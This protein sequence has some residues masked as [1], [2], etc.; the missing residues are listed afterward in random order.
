MHPVVAI[1]AHAVVCLRARICVGMRMR[2]N[3]SC[4]C[5][6]TT[7]VVPA[8]DF[9]LRT[10]LMFGRHGTCV[11]REARVLPGQHDIHSTMLHPT[12]V[13]KQGVHRSYSRRTHP[14]HTQEAP[15]GVDVS[16]GSTSDVPLNY[17]RWW[18]VASRSGWHA[19]PGGLPSVHMCPVKILIPRYSIKP[20][21]SGV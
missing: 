20:N 15:G 19:A 10:A 1:A 9:R 5:G 18:D 7:R 21:V 4:S 6:A 8:K 13:R 3:R 2:A 12:E 11:P 17:V 16:Y 14:Q